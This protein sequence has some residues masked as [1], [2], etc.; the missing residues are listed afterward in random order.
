V[1]AKV[2]DTE[3]LLE[4]G[5]LKLQRTWTHGDTVELTLSMS[6]ERIEAHPSVRHN[7]GRIALQ[8]GPII[9]CLEEID[10]G[11]ELNDI[12]A[13]RSSRLSVKTYRN[14]LG[15]I[16]VITAK[17]Q[18]RDPSDWDHILYRPAGSSQIQDTIITAIPYFMWANRD[19]GEMLVWIRE[20]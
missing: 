4:K 15:G 11:K 5:Y 13:P 17:A 20:V 14:L 12:V 3:K 1:N 8:R 7:C 16:P 10:N 6:P 9:Y 2:I 18:R 19:P